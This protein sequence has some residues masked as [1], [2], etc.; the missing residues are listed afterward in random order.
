MIW[1]RAKDVLIE[2]QIFALKIKIYRNSYIEYLKNSYIYELSS[3]YFL[4]IKVNTREVTMGNLDIHAFSYI[5]NLLF[6]FLL[7]SI[8]ETNHT[9]K[10]KIFLNI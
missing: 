5:N 6:L 7:D 9:N 2:K 10:I 1:N 4:I 3:F 8:I